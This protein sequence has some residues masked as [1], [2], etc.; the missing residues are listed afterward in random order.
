MSKLD[1]GRLAA[2]ALKS[3]GVSHIFTLCVASLAPYYEGCEAEGIKVIGMRS[4]QGAATAADG[5]SRVT[6]K[7]GVAMFTAGPA[8]TNAYTGIANAYLAPSP[9]VYIGRGRSNQ[10]SNDLGELMEIDK[11]YLEL[12]RP[13]TKWSRICYDTN[14][15]PEYISM[16][17]RN[18]LVGKPGPAYLEV[19]VDAVFRQVEQSEV[20]FPRDYRT[21]AK[22][23][24]D[25]S[26]VRR[27]SEMLLKAQRPVVVGGGG[28][29]WSQASEALQRLTA[30]LELP[31]F[32]NGLGRGSVPPDHPVYFS[33]ARSTALKNADVILLVGAPLDFRLSF[34]RPPAWSADAKVI[35]ID[36]DPAE[37]GRNRNIDVGIPGDPKAILDQLMAE[38][39]KKKRV[40]SDWVNHLRESEK[41]AIAR[42]EELMKSD[43]DPIHPMR[44]MGELRKLLDPDDI[45]VGDGGFF[46]NFAARVLK[47]HKPGHWL[48]PGLMG[49]LGVGPGFAI[50]AKLAHPEKR[51]VLISGDGS[52]GFNGME[53]ETMSR[54]GI[55]IVTIVGND[56]SWGM[57]KY[58]PAWKDKPI[59]AD[60]SRDT[61]YDIVAKGLGCQG[62]LVEHP[63]GIRA[64]LVRA[65]AADCPALV[66][67]V[68]TNETAVYQSTGRGVFDRIKSSSLA[69]KG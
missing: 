62:E 53:L 61:R 52:F 6:G 17:F 4:E 50:A 7:P 10:A 67:V 12:A 38:I 66:N 8:F 46:V 16:A 14:R 37:I 34:G 48:D 49:C 56:G 29:H 27:A 59:A 65:L 63:D 40:E 42:D 30:A 47:I 60:L 9:V 15:I 33:Y 55:N 1:G 43:I 68:L 23:Y 20:Y 3:E 31:V 24:G 41:E 36:I 28:V 21:E 57:E 54:Y 13:I 18:A 69:S 26:Y 11:E 32:L 51:V 25:P 35:Q 58:I 19:P 45:V 39:S 64:A 22:A 2:K 5:W 44:V